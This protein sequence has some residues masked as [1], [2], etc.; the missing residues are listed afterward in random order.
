MII[1][2]LKNYLLTHEEVFKFIKNNFL[3]GSTLTINIL[4]KKN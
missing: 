3:Q 2:S 1:F 4:A